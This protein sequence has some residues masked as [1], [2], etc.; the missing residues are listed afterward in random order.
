MNSLPFC[1]SSSSINI[2]LVF[3]SVFHSVLLCI[4]IFWFLTI[5]PPLSFFCKATSTVYISAVCILSSSS[6]FSEFTISLVLYPLH[7]IFSF[8]SFFQAYTYYSYF[9]LI[10]LFSI[11]H[12][13]NIFLLCSTCSICSLVRD[14]YISIAAQWCWLKLIILIHISHKVSSLTYRL[15]VN[16]G[17]P[18]SLDKLPSGTIRDQLI[19][20]P[21]TT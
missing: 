11:V 18:D 6:F 14:Y 17:L 4:S 5:S 16:P 3:I 15:S 19:A 13:M 9:F 21:S 10:R 8:L 7:E 2:R 1:H 20:G 12:G